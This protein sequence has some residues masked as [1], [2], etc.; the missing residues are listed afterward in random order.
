[1]TALALSKLQLLLSTWN[2]RRMEILIFPLLFRLMIWSG[3]FDSL[4]YEEQHLG[5]RDLPFALNKQPFDGFRV[6]H[7]WFWKQSQ[8]I[9][10]RQLC[11]CWVLFFVGFFLDSI[12]KDLTYFLGK[13]WAHIKY[14]SDHRGG[15]AGAPVSDLYSIHF[16]LIVSPFAIELNTFFHACFPEN[17]SEY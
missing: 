10:Y 9:I 8:V 16:K 3:Y 1:M 7:L 13:F 12:Y 6:S 11:F 5:W 17:R 2:W 15:T 4:L 14:S